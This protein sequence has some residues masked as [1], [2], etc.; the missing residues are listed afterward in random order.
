MASKKPAAKKPAAKTGTAVA[1]RAATNV[2]SIRE[3]LKKD[4]QGVDDRTSAPGGDSIII[5]QD[6]HF[7]LPTGEKTQG[8]ID[9]LIVDFVSYNAYYDGLKYDPKDIRPPGCFAISLSPKN[10]KPSGNSK[11]IQ[12]KSCDEC[13]NN[14]FGSDGEGKACKNMRMLAVLPPDADETTP[15]AVIKVS[16]TAIKGFDAYV[17]SVTAKFDTT[18]AALLTEVSFDPDADYPTLR[19]GNPRPADDDLLALGFAARET[20]RKRLM[21]EP[22]VS[23][24]TPVQKKPVKKSR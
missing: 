6:K 17:R 2:V 22:D 21:Q 8:P 14:E 13:P 7:K 9:V 16:P 10:M 18:P 11:N 20:A 23:G 3:Q 5:T 19:F 12:A 4:A 24:W 1:P 15:L